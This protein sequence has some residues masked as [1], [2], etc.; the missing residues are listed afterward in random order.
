MSLLTVLA[1][2]AAEPC[3]TIT[4]LGGSFPTLAP[5]EANTVA[6]HRCM[7]KDKRKE[8]IDERS[9]DTW[10]LSGHVSICDF[11]N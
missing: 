7:W 2:G 11:F 10:L 8:Q 5:V 4:E 6:T 3:G 9:R 1:A